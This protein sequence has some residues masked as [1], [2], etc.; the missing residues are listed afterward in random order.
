[1]RR[2]CSAA[3]MVP[4]VGAASLARRRPHGGDVLPCEAATGAAPRLGASGGERRSDAARA[5][6][7]ARSSGGGAPWGQIRCLLV[8]IRRGVEGATR[9]GS[10]EVEVAARHQGLWS[11]VIRAHGRWIRPSSRSP[12]G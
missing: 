11:S 3:G 4:R 12:L 2:W 10:L 7:T 5:A 8:W 9:R 1:V 6:T